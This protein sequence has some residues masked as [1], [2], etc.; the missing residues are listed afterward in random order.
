M[1]RD[2]E[3]GILLLVGVGFDADE[4]L[5]EW[6]FDKFELFKRAAKRKELESRRA[7]VE[8]VAS[9]VGGV[10]GG[11]GLNSYLRELK[12]VVDYDL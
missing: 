2:I 5:Y 10:L 11:K 8:D 1:A 12:D 6:P 7:F 4:V 3:E 9:A